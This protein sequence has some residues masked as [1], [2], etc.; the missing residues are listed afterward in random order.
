MAF[1][2]SN[3]HIFKTCPDMPGFSN[4]LMKQFAQLLFTLGTSTK[5][6][7]KLEALSDY[8][9]HADAKDKV[10]V[11]ALFSGRRPRR[12]VSGT[13]LA[14]W[15]TELIGLPGWLFEECYHTVGDLSETIAL[16]IPEKNNS[17]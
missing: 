5:T 1:T 17:S 16:L 8:F 12:T 14:T 7:D 10:W 3:D 11:I 9:A 15:C 2:F 4:Q 13:Q 6:N